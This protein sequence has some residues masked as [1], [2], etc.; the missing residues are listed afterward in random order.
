M[1]VAGRVART[2][3]DG[4]FP[5]RCPHPI[6]NLTESGQVGPVLSQENLEETA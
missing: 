4:A 3:A 5:A 2:G 6:R 1:Q